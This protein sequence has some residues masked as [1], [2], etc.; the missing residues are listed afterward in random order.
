ML[1]VRATR[2]LLDHANPPRTVEGDRDT[3]LLGPWYATALF[4]RPR[5][6]LLVNERTLLPA[7]LPLAPVRSIP[8]RIPDEIATVLDAHR[9][10]RA[11]T[12]DELRNMQDCRF[13]PTASRSVVGIMNEFSKLAEI[14]A[15]GSARTNLVALSLRLARTPCSPLYG[16]NVSPDREL[17]ALIRS[18]AA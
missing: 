3:T 14:Y 6:A 8:D 2:K 17:A 12:V 5:L 9:V 15:N 13:A 4:W 10:P 7:L 16:K 1:I 18:T 11:I